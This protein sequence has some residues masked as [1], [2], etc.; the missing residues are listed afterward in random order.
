MYIHAYMQDIPTC[1]PFTY[2]YIHICIFMR[3]YV[4]CGVENIVGH[5]KV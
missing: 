3:I 2:V 4:V 1:S 5:A